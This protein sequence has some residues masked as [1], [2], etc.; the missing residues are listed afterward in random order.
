M[1]HLDNATVMVPAMVTV[2]VRLRV[3]VSIAAPTVMVWA[4]AIMQISTETQSLPTAFAAHDPGMRGE[5]AHAD[6]DGMGQPRDGTGDGWG[7]G[8]SDGN[9]NGW[10]AGDGERSLT[11]DGPVWDPQ[12]WHITSSCREIGDSMGMWRVA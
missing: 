7:C 4:T 5:V 11:G 2:A 9:G 1:V 3:V 10:G 8:Y 12:T 6:G